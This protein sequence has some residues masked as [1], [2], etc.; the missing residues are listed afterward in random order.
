MK[1]IHLKKIRVIIAL[2]FFL[3]LT[4]FFIDFRKHLPEFLYDSFSYLQFI[5]SILKFVSMLSISASGFIIVL[6]LTSVFGRIYCSSICPLGILQDI[7]SW[8]NKKTRRKFRF[9]YTSPV[10]YL[11]YP[12]LALPVV[13]YLAGSVFLLLL[14]DPFSN[15]GRIVSDIFQPVYL[16]I[17]NAG[18]RFL[19]KLNVYF[20]YPEDITFASWETYI[21]PIF[22]LALVIWMTVSKGRLF[23]NS[24]CPV[25]TLLGLLSRIS[26]FRIS[27]L[28]DQ[29]TQCG[30]CAVVC[31][32]TCIRIK[33]LNVDFSRCVGC[34]NCISVCPEAAIKYVRNKR[35]QV[36]PEEPGSRER[37]EAIQTLGLILFGIFGFRRKLYSQDIQQDGI[38]VVPPQNT[39][40]TEI[41]PEKNYPVSPPGSLGIDHFTGTCTACHLCVS[42]CPTQV[43]QPSLLEYGFTGIMQ[44]YMNY[45]VNYCNF[46]CV[47]CSEV[48]PTGAILSLSKE[49]KKITQI[50][51]VV[52]ILESCIVYTDNTSCGSCSEHCPTKAVKMVPYTSALTIPETNP[53][54]C[55]GCGACEY[56]CPTKP[57]K[58]IYV[59]GHSIHKVAKEP[60]TEELEQPDLEED[61]PF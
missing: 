36:I 57:Y 31:K 58:A 17:N 3:S 5:P 10:N 47:I 7:I 15:F 1:Q 41:K 26:V 59:D 61:F 60:E 4:F 34:F 27:M 16:G 33:D 22:I 21:F 13:F 53:D 52:F 23:C 49:A 19:E 50:G 18:S 37:R 35:Q 40:P 30:K 42:A 6:V 38:P 9:R 39:F 45:N 32:S 51:Q 44:P 43:L 20:L 8:V 29:C 48:C 55:V 46:E 2:I 24:V 25:G 54:I 12:L 11:R 14:L 56:A 28:K